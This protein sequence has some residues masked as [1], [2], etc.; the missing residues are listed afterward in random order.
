MLKCAVVLDLLPQYLEGLT[1]E[2]TNEEI[3]EHLAGCE[4]CRAA[5]QAMGLEL[6]IEKAPKPNRDFLKALNRR[7]ILGAVIS[8]LA[9][10]GCAVGLY[11]M[12]FSVDASDTMRL[13]AAIA[14]YNHE[15]MEVDVAETVKIGK[16]LYVLYLREDL[17][18]HYGLAELERGIFGKYRFHSSSNSDWPLYNASAGKVRGQE[19]L[20]IFGIYDLPGVTRYTAR[21]WQGEVLYEAP[22]E[23]APFLR[24]VELEETADFFPSELASYYDE[25]GSELTRRQLVDALPKA[26]EGQNWS[27]G[28]AEMGMV[29]FFIA[30]ILALGVILVRYFLLP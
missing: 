18:G 15:E 10:L 6:S 28:S 7:R 30:V 25:N 19:Y 29:Y 2:E 8:A 26:A 16:Y 17:S 4:A 27:V 1:S 9:A 14:E 20:L 12:E 11:F 23:T 21:D 24:V 3:R 5:K 13:E 22:A